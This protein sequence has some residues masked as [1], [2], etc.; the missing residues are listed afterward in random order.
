MAINLTTKNPHAP[1]GGMLA[2]TAPFVPGPID[3]IGDNPGIY[4]KTDP[5][6]PFT[7]LMVWFRIQ[8]SPQGPG[9]MLLLME[10][11]TLATVQGDVCNVCVTDNPALADELLANYCTRFGVFRGQ[12]AFGALRR[13]PISAVAFDGDPRSTVSVT[14][15]TAGDAPMRIALNWSDLGEP[16]AADVPPAQSATGRH[17]M[18]SIF[19]ESRD[20]WI[21]VD[22]RRLPGAPVIR[23]FMGRPTA[24]AFLAMCECWI[25]QG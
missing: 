2:M 13:L 19:A 17:R 14:V 25:R 16:F 7:S 20:A 4:L 6:G 5:A 22:G 11:P 21:T 3:W 9:H 1:Q 15:T 18:T 8:H 23:D 10:D 24:S 12:P